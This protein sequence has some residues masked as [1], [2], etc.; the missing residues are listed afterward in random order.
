MELLLIT[1]FAD[2]INRG[3]VSVNDCWECCLSFPVPELFGQEG[4]ILHYGWA[5]LLLHLRDALHEPH[6]RQLSQALVAD[7]DALAGLAFNPAIPNLHLAGC[8]APA[9]DPLLAER[10]L[11]G[12]MAFS[13]SDASLQ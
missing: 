1:E 3:E 10:Q 5:P 9:P 2:P 4:R 13:R 11:G 8:I 6:L 7:Y 12:V